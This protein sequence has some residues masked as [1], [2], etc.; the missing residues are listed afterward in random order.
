M[1]VGYDPIHSELDTLNLFT[2]CLIRQGWLS[3]IKFSENILAH[4]SNFMCSLIQNKL[5]NFQGIFSWPNY[6]YFLNLKLIC[7]KI[8]P[9]K[10]W[11]KHEWVF[12]CV[13]AGVMSCHRDHQNVSLVRS[14]AIK[15][16][17]QTR[18]SYSYHQTVVCVKLFLSYTETMLVA[19]IVVQL[20]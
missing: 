3:A 14:C 17:N 15:W 18:S 9:W 19:N 13:L 4:K 16:F 5:R 2:A 8:W 6:W 12:L 20:L 7:I 11:S 10:K 1:S